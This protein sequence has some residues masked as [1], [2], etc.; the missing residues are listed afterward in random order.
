MKAER[1]TRVYLVLILLLAGMTFGEFGCARKLALPHRWRPLSKIEPK[2]QM[3]IVE[4]AMR[5][6][7][8]VEVKN[9]T[10][11][12]VNASHTHFVN[13]LGIDKHGSQVM[14]G[15]EPTK[16]EVVKMV[17]LCPRKIEDARRV[18]ISKE[19]AQ[20]QCLAFLKKKKLTI[21]ENYVLEESKVVSLGPWKRWRFV[22]RHVEKDVRVLPDFIT[23]EV[24]A[25][26]EADV[27]S[28]SKVHHEVLVELTPKLASS[29]AVMRARRAV[30]G[31]GDLRPIRSDLSV[32]YPNEFFR[33]QVWEWSDEQA[34]C[35]ILK[36]YRDEHHVVDIWVDALTGAIRGG[37]ICHLHTPEVFGIDSPTY[38]PT[39][40]QSH[41]DNVWTPYLDMM[42]FDVT[43]FDWTNANAGFTEATISNAISNGRYFIVEGH[44]DV[45][46][47]AEEMII[48]YQGTADAQTFTPDEVPANNLRLAFLD[49]CQ[50]GED[51]T[52]TDFKDTF[53]SQGSDVFV[54]FDDYMCAWD[55][56]ERLLHYLAQGMALANAH[57]LADAD[58][59][60]WYTIV[61]TYNVG[62]LNMV[63]LAPL[64]VTV[65][66]SPSGNVTS[67]GTFTVTASIN[68]KEDVDH[69]PATNVLANLVLPAGFTITSGANPQTIGTVNWHSPTAT[70]WTVRA[71]IVAGTYT[72]DVEVSSDNLG[73][74]VDDPDDP[75]HKF[76]V[77]VVGP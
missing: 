74:E 70:T 39:H 75:Y 52:G 24:N 16:R 36:F 57:N 77:H 4:K 35:W 59:S 65:S 2:E 8:I 33:K 21:P 43:S 60:P 26:E 1:N 23:L 53:I 58:V 62:C 17:K 42:R 51:G 5:F 50:S 20:S 68:N 34:L 71:P 18:T 40:M 22:W 66:R 76:D 54:G 28:Y 32:V 12:R 48:A 72:L 63:R 47:T 25:S 49:V 46:A 44:G 3:R 61:I 37:I 7:G 11:P 15:V 41:L 6:A 29:E 69:T 56:E 9:V 38:I 67:G 14:V 64:S 31:V 10:Y 55:Y 19:Q 30:V 27:I 45:T 73:V 13:V